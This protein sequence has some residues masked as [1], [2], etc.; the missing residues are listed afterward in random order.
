MLFYIGEMT[1]DC[2]TLPCNAQLFL[3]VCLFALSRR[4][5]EAA[6]MAAAVEKQKVTD[7]YMYFLHPYHTICFYAGFE[8]LDSHQDNRHWL[9]KSHIILSY[10]AFLLK[11]RNSEDN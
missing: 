8:N 3:F 10:P 4:E 7:R 5:A 2:M 9:V 11:Y 6:A 1:L